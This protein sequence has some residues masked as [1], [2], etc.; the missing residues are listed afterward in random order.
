MSFWRCCIFLCGMHYDY[1]IFWPETYAPVILQ[2]R[3]VHLP[4]WSS[5]YLRLLRRNARGKRI[6]RITKIFMQRWKNWTGHEW[7]S[8]RTLFRPF[9][10]MAM[11]LILLLVTIYTSLV[12]GILY[13]REQITKSHQNRSVNSDVV[14]EALP[15]GFIVLFSLS[16]WPNLCRCWYRRS[17]R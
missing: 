8:G 10:M 15:I 2:R 7:V 17:A 1:H 16:T 5:I 11:E 12:Y 14:L 6:P 3:S 13:G 9:H 4:N